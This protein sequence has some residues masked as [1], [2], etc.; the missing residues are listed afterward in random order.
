MYITIR[1]ETSI[2]SV[3]QSRNT[4]ETKQIVS[5]GNTETI[6]SVLKKEKESGSS[7]HFHLSF[8]PFS[9]ATPF[10]ISHFHFIDSNVSIT[11]NIL[12]DAIV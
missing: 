12:R 5:F 6:E 9:I 3:Y 10:F 4:E 2:V 1:C 8:F 7:N 11:G